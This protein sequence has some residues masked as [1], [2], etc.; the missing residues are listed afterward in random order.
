M[1]GV[2]KGWDP[3]VNLVLDD[4]VEELRGEPGE[5]CIWSDNVS[6]LEPSRTDCLIFFSQL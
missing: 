2:L 3:L 6:S 4:A 5:R 1:R